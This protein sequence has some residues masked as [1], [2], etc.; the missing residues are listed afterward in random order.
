MSMPGKKYTNRYKSENQSNKMQFFK[1]E[2]SEL[3]GEL[4]FNDAEIY[5]LIVN[6]YSS[7]NEGED[8][9]REAKRGRRREGGEKGK[10]GKITK[11]FVLLL[12]CFFLFI[13]V[14]KASKEEEEVQ[15]LRWRT[16]FSRAQ[17]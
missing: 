11:K 7:K 10:T 2:K 3:F 5:S 13:L 12:L 6:I 17:P 16:P 1:S 8:E 9:E 14:V 15:N 4:S